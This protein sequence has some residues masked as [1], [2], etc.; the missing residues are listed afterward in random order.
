MLNQLETRAKWTLKSSCHPKLNHSCSAILYLY[1]MQIFSFVAVK[2]NFFLFKKTLMLIKHLHIY[3][4]Q[5]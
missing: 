4:Y 5:A 1:F 2:E 3:M